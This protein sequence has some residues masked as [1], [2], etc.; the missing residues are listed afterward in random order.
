MNK[1]NKYNWLCW[2]HCTTNPTH[3]KCTETQLTLYLYTGKK[4][5]EIS[6]TRH[7]KQKHWF[8]IDSDT[9][10]RQCDCGSNGP[11]FEPR[12]LVPLWSKARNLSHLSTDRENQ[13]CITTPLCACVIETSAHA[14]NWATWENF[15]GKQERMNKIKETLNLGRNTKWE[16]IGKGEKRVI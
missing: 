11:R 15:A 6:F 14:G 8:S 16:Q 3:N 1:S 10:S 4:R 9:V 7:F 12:P 2:G 13:A 5:Y